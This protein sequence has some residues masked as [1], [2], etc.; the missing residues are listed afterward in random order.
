MILILLLKNYG[1]LTFLSV[2]NKILIVTRAD[3]LKFK[4]RSTMGS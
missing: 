1:E 2:E 3:S 4:N